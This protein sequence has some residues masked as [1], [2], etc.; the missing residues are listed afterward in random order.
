[1][2]ISP[3]TALAAWAVA[4]AWMALFI[5]FERWDPPG[6]DVLDWIGI[7]ATVAGIACFPLVRKGFAAWLAKP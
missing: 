7:A 6:I 5:L 4:T 2:R 1:M 3:P